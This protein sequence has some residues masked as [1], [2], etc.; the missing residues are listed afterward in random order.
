MYSYP[1]QRNSGKLECVAARTPCRRPAIM[2]V[3]SDAAKQADGDS[4]PAET[5]A[6]PRIIANTS[7]RSAPT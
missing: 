3:A 4:Q 2:R 1:E 7:R 5:R 6:L